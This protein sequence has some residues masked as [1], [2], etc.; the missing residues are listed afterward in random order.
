MCISIYIYTYLSFYLSIIYLSLS[1][2]LSL[3]LCLARIHGALFVVCACAR[4]V[5]FVNGKDGDCG[6][7]Q[8]LCRHEAFERLLYQAV[9]ELVIRVV[10]NSCLP[11]CPQTTVKVGTGHVSHRHLISDALAVRGMQKHRGQV[12]SMCT[13]YS[14]IHG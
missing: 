1:L 2:S 9:S 14:L 10:W 4:T 3:S 5:L 12:F 6:W 11:K 13:P 8:S 7:Y